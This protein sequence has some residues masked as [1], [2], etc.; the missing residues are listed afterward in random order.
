MVAEMSLSSFFSWAAG[1]FHVEDLSYRALSKDS[2]IRLL[3][4]HKGRDDQPIRC[5]IKTVL[6]DDLPGKYA[7]LSYVWGSP[8]NKHNILCDGKRLSVTANLYSALR[9]IRPLD[10]SL[11]L[12]IDAICI[13]QLD[14]AERESQVRMMRRIYQQAQCVAV[15]LGEEAE[16]VELILPLLSKIITQLKQHGTDWKLPQIQF[17]EFGLPPAE[18]QDWKAL[19]LLLCRPWFR[20]VWI[21]QE[22]ALAQN[23]TIVYGNTVLPWEDLY[24]TVLWLNKHGMFAHLAALGDDL[25]PNGRE[26]ALRASVN[27]FN[28]VHIRN[29]IQRGTPKSFSRCLRHVRAFEATDPRDRAYGLLGLI[30][31]VDS[32]GF[33]VIY[34][35]EETLER[36]FIRLAQALV[37]SGDAYNVL[38]SAGP[39]NSSMNVP[40]WVPDWTC[41]QKQTQF[42]LLRDQAKKS[43]YHAGGPERL[44][45]T[46]IED[47]QELSV[48]GSLFDNILL[49]GDAYH[50][51]TPKKGEGLTKTMH[52]EAQTH[53]LIG[54]LLSYPTGEAI[55]DVYRRVLVANK[56]NREEEAST[57]Y[58]ENYERMLR[59]FHIEEQARSPAEGRPPLDFDEEELIALSGSATKYIKSISSCI[60]GRK[61]CVTRKGYIGLVSED[62]IEGDTI[63]VFVGADVPFVLRRCDDRYKLLG[64]C[65]IHGIMNEEI[66]E[67]KDCV[68]RDIILI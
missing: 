4:L 61:L 8:E 13:N 11:T 52:W 24:V 2:E 37:K 26:V 28:I 32:F 41:D 18:A 3:E 39:K 35:S 17:E 30:P 23:L 19:V 9:R 60:S 14:V 6:L 48:R 42:S 7:A 44:L 10:Y 21:I 45:A 40:S 15:D 62:A 51:P 59:L 58:I 38:L 54:N 43:L 49:T 65:Y 33:E 46:I 1:F 25:F 12:W 29:G 36:V 5:S 27:F 47:S 67:M 66:L 31:N 64:D 55:H 22:Y 16:G 63:C 57:S 20:R 50:N 68:I 56:D 34:S 53:A